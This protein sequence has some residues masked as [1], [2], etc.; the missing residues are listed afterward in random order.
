[1]VLDE[2]KVQRVGY[3]LAS[4]GLVG[5]LG[6]GLVSLVGGCAGY[7]INDISLNGNEVSRNIKNDQGIRRSNSEASQLI[8]YT[9][10][11]N[12]DDSDF[13]KIQI[14]VAIIGG[15]IIS[16]GIGTGIYF[17][18]KDDGHSGRGYSVG[19]GDDGTDGIG[20]K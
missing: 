16:V 18:V 4:R 12:N 3:N 7:A 6:T 11:V 9:N 13:T 19:T 1:M 10:P 14:V 5:V 15:A 2:K 20:G 8:V 17:L